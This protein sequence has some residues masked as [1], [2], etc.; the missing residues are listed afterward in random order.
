MNLDTIKNAITSKVGRQILQGQ[1]HSPAILFG[2]GIAAMV[3]TV[4]VAS[5]ATLKLDQV[6]EKAD[7]DKELAAEA[8]AFGTE[9]YTEDDYRKDCM[10]IQL[11]TAGNVAKLYGPALALGLVSVAA[12]TGSHVVLTRRNVAMTAAYAAIDK[13]FREY[14]DRVMKKLG[15]D[16]EREL[17]FDCEDREI[18]EET[19]N[20]PK[21]KIV[22]VSNGKS[23][24]A[25]LFDEKS[26]MWSKGPM[27]N[28]LTVRCQQT[29]ANDILHARGH[30][31]LNEVK[32]MLGLPRTPEGQLVG[33]VVN[34]G[35]DNFVDFGVLEGD[36]FSAVRFVNGDE[37]SIWLDFNV[38]GIVY[39]LI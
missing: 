16:K 37:R 34:K 5:R 38:D 7:K 39:D 19:K 31:F 36:L 20:G 26:T 11:K 27:N 10:L 15:P 14:R 22:K 2:V 32:D 13:S 30:L 9:D 29:F 35:G 24:Y 1:K 18:V 3:G 12:L 21:T 8:R 17:R 4:V 28:Q 6:L 23:P 25:V 33:W